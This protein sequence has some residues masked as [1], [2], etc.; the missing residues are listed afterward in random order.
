[1]TLIRHRGPVVR[2]PEGLTLE[3]PP[4]Q[5]SAT[6]LEYLARESAKRRGE[7]VPEPERTVVPRGEVHVVKLTRREVEAMRAARRKP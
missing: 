1:M 3:E 5:V 6:M 7:L 2:L 4:K